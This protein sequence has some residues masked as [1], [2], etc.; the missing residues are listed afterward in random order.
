MLRKRE[1]SPARPVCGERKLAFGVDHRVRRIQKR[2]LF[3]HVLKETVGGVESLHSASP[4]LRHLAR[5]S[6]LGYT[7]PELKRWLKSWVRRGGVAFF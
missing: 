4:L 3:G 2:S 6:A 7:E 1:Q 5:H